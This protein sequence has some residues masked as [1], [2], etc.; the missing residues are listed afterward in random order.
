MNKVAELF[1]KLVPALLIVISVFASGWFVRGWSDAEDRL[2]EEKAIAEQR[3]A[4]EKLANSTLLELKDTLSDIK[5]QGI[6][7]RTIV[8]KETQ[9]PVY[10]QQCFEQSGVDIVNQMAKGNKQ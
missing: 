6:K 8:Q 7:E 3:I 9:K 10:S 2:K 4:I 1:Y 5:A